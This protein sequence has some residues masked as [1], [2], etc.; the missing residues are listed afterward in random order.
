M[1]ETRVL[2]AEDAATSIATLV[3]M[4][5]SLGYQVAGVGFFG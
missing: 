4:L 5:N 2:I 1:A 3:A